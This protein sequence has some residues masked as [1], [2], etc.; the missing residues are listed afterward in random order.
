MSVP[1]LR[2]F[3]GTSLFCGTRREASQDTASMP[4]TSFPITRVWIS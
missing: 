2:E 3:S 4:V 1:N